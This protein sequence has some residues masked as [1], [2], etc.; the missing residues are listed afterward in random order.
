MEHLDM[1]GA[2]ICE[3]DYVAG[4][5]GTEFGVF[6]VNKCAP[7]T[8]TMRN[9]LA[10]SKRGRERN[11]RRY[12]KDLIKLSELQEKAILVKILKGT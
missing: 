2:E 1:F 5:Y 9:V 6:K 4:I 7:K 12:A 11:H 3:D 8:L 10:K